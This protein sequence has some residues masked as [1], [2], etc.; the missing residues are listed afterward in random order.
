MSEIR[1]YNRLVK[2]IAWL[3]VTFKVRDV[4]SQIG[5]KAVASRI[6]DIRRTFPFSSQKEAI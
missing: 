1:R 4:H 3:E 6:R 5:R 2:D